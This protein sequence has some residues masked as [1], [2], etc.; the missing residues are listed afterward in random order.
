MANQIRLTKWLAA[1]LLAVFVFGLQGCDTGPK[2]QVVGFQGMTMGTTFSMKWVASSEDELAAVRTDAGKL[3]SRVNQQMSTY[4]DDSELSLL[5]QMPHGQVRSVSPELMQVLAEGRR[6]SVLTGGAFDYTV[7]PL[8][9]LWGFGPDGRIT[10][11]PE[12]AEIDSL[13]SRIGYDFVELDPQA[14]TV[15]KQG[16]QY[17]DLSAIA[18]GYG[19]DELARLLE[20]RGIERYL[21]EI[22]GELR[23]RGTKPNGES[24]KLAIETPTQGERSVQEIIS[25]TTGGVATSGDYR[26]YFEEDGVRFSHTIDPRTARPIT[27][28]LASVT[29]IRPT[30]MEA[31][32]LATALM[33]M[34]EEEGYNFALEHEIDA[35]FISKTDEGFATRFTPGFANYMN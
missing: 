22:G 30:C 9:N 6:I 16:E 8:V 20:A 34:G 21:V 17:V 33:V 2:E 1:L 25:L 11:A 14:Q 28:R 5:N 3:L 18:K 12:Q 31:D 13:K 27:H 4:I 24:W 10:H 19:V 35:F 32:A 26:N 15:G 29:V 23:A 7:G